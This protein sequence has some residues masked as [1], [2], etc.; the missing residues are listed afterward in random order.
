MLEQQVQHMKEVEQQLQEVAITQETEIHRL[1]SA[2]TIS[3]YTM[4]SGDVE[5]LNKVF[6]E[7]IADQVCLWHLHAQLTAS[8]EKRS[9]S[10]CTEV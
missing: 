4:S 3:T 1:R 2:S 5:I 7:G 9:W 10:N 6:P 8:A